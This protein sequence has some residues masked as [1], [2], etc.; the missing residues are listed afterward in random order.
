[1]G[2]MSVCRR[3][4]VG[5]IER[6]R[7]L[8]KYITDSFLKQAENMPLADGC[9]DVAVSVC[10]LC[11]VRSA[12]ATL[13][14]I[15]RVLKPGWRLM[16]WE[17]VRSE[18]CPEIA[19]RQTECSAQ[20]EINWGCRFDRRSLDAIRAAGFS[21]VHGSYFELPGFDLMGPTILGSAVK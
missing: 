11:S 3:H 5:E 6:D 16:F 2:R 18:T 1:M 15:R 8:D 20:E 14:E 13:R 19:S 10:V 9:I 12:S 17:H 4:I 21:Q 7:G